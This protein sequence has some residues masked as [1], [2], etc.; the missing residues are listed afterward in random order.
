[1][2]D[3]PR[4]TSNDI[5][6]ISAYMNYTV[7]GDFKFLLNPINVQILFNEVG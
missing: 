6:E 2:E 5:F 3:K 1:M 4:C 7:R